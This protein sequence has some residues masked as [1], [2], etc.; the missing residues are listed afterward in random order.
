MAQREES[1]VKNQLGQ[2]HLRLGK[3]VIGF[4]MGNLPYLPL[5]RSLGSFH[6]LEQAPVVHQL[7]YHFGVGWQS[8]H[9]RL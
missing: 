2:C 1:P 7:A 8:F 3:F 4:L 5:F 9:L 6:G